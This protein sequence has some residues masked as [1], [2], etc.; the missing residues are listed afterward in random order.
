MRLPARLIRTVAFGAI[1][2]LA[3]G[4]AATMFIAL[5]TAMFVGV[6]LPHV[7]KY[8]RQNAPY[9]LLAIGFIAAGAL[10][11]L[12]GGAVKGLRGK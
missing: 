9:G 3:A 12:L 1:G 8:M 4:L 7:W 5:W 6:P 11:G 2:C 10:A